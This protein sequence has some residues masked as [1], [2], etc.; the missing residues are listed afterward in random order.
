MTILISCSS[1]QDCPEKTNLL[2]MYGRLKKCDEQLKI[3]K[4]FLADCD[5]IFKDRNEATRHHIDKGWEYFYK[6][7][8]DTAMMRFNQAWLLDSTNADIYWGFGN[9]LGKQNKF[10]ESIPYFDKSLKLNPENSKVWLCAATSYGQLF[11]QSKNIALLNKAINNLKISVSLDSTNI[12]AYAQLTACYSFFVQKDS[13][14]KYLNITDKLGAKA[15]NPE[16]RRL[17]EEK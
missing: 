1:K 11:F 3:D 13:A 4:E 2:P 12:E 5:K 9:I 6:N 8:L 16:L 7:D 17:L 15:I 14:R 10:K